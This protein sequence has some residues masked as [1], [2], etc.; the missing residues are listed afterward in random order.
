VAS[1]WK[2]TRKQKQLDI[3]DEAF[4][5]TASELLATNIQLNEASAAASKQRSRLAAAERQQI[6]SE[7][8]RRRQQEA[9]KKLQ[10]ERML[11]MRDMLEKQIHDQARHEALSQQRSDVRSQLEL[12]R[13]IAM[14]QSLEDIAMHSY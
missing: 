14:K 7:R 1:T 10:E 6:V 13:R 11:I 8:E 9:D 5:R 4:E 2:P 3:I 12:Q